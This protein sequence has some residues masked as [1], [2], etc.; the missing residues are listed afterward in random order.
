[1]KQ[2]DNYILEKLMLNKKIKD[3]KH[4]VV[5]SWKDGGA[6]Y[7]IYDSAEDAADG[8]RRGDGKKFNKTGSFSLTI[9]IGN[10]NNID[11]IISL[12]Y[13][14]LPLDK[15]RK[16]FIKLDADFDNEVTDLLKKKHQLDL[17]NEKHK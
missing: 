12:C 13:K 7:I 14:G 4:M 15:Q 3:I 11:K 6:N 1:M 16:E 9:Q 5:Y 17:E 10:E 2:L 8:I